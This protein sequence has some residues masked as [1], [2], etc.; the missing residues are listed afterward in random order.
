MSPFYIQE[1][2]LRDVKQLTVHHRVNK[3]W[4]QESNLGVADPQPKLPLEDLSLPSLLPCSFRL[5]SGAFLPRPH[6][7]SAPLCTKGRKEEHPLLG[8]LPV[9]SSGKMRPTEVIKASTGADWKMSQCPSNSGRLLPAG[10]SSAP[11]THK[12]KHLQPLKPANSIIKHQHMLSLEREFR[13]HESHCPGDPPLQGN[14]ED[15]RLCLAPSCRHRAPLAQPS[16]RGRDP[17]IRRGHSEEQWAGPATMT[18][19]GPSRTPQDS[20]ASP[21]PCTTQLASPVQ[22]HPQELGR[23]SAP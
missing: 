14:Q 22:G 11:L 19:L 8:K 10:P 3:Q 23:L 13:D 16:C 18:T 20:T 15:R 12:D 17:V 4:N 6:A 5:V 2:R 9:V 21:T 7:L 1:N